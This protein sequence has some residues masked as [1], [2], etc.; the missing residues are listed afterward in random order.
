MSI[1]KWVT[2]NEKLLVLQGTKLEDKAETQVVMIT[3]DNKQSENSQ[4]YDKNN[5]RGNRGN[6]NR[7]QNGWNSR[8]QGSNQGQYNDQSVTLCG[9]CSLIKE[10]EVSQ[11]YMTCT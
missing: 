5:G 10:N 4:K 9:L 11:E 2:D 7:R 8:Q 1:K 6:N 3:T